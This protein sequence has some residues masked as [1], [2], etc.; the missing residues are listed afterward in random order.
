[1]LRTIVEN[2]GFKVLQVYPYAEV[3]KQVQ[4]GDINRYGQF[5][6]FA[7]KI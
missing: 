6:L 1:M 7:E 3:E 4:N 2:H 5:V